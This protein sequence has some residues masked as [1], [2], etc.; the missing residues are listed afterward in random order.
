[1]K[2][3]GGSV[4]LNDKK[5]KRSRARMK[6][7]D[8]NATIIEEF[9]ILKAIYKNTDLPMWVIKKVCVMFLQV[10]KERLLHG[11]YIY[12]SGLGAFVPYRRSVGDRRF[13]TYDPTRMRTVYR[14]KG[15]PTFKKELQA[16]T[17]RTEEIDAS[18]SQSGG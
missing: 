18:S 3:Q 6:G 15:T 9:H 17:L 1:M 2:G 13:K 8:P 14:W 4:V 5:R 7:S 10:M 16:S 12:F 11:D